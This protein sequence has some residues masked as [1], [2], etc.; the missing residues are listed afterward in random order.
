MSKTMQ[1]LQK[2]PQGSQPECQG[3]ELGGTQHL[4]VDQERV[5]R[6]LK[7]SLKS[8]RASTSR[9]DSVCLQ[10]REASTPP[11]VSLPEPGGSATLPPTA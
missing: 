4:P 8:I 3:R 9:I 11:A 2:L 10:W 7:D 5:E 6:A 1:L